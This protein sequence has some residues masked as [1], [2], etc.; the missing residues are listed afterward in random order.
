MVFQGIH[1]S[2]TCMEFCP[3]LRPSKAKS[4]DGELKIVSQKNH[5]KLFLVETI[6]HS[7]VNG[8]LITEHRSPSFHCEL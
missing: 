2:L 4:R 8:G 1:V 6:T 7:S 3:Y 5:F